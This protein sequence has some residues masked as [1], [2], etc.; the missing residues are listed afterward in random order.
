[1]GLMDRVKELLGGEGLSGVVESTG[2]G[3]H[4]ESLVGEGGVAET[5]GIDASGLT[6]GLGDRLPGGLG[7]HLEPPA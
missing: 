7:E 6:E 2:L 1:M 5:L 3:E 4:V